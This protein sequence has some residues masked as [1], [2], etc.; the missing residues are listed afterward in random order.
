MNFFLP[1]L[2]AFLLSIFFTLLIRHVSLQKGIVDRPS[3]DL[4]RKVHERPIPLLGGFA[5]WAAFSITVLL[6]VIVAPSRFHESYLLFKHIFGIILGGALLMVG[7]YLDDRFGRSPRQQIIW[8]ILAALTVI[9]SGVGIA[10]ITNPF[11]GTIPL[12]QWIV[13]VVTIAGTPY[14]IVLFADVFA[15]L[16]LMVAM[17]ATKFLDG[18][19][20]LVSGVA[21]IGMLIIFA[22]SQT[23]EVGQPETALLALIAAASFAGFLIFNFHPAKIF[24]G[25]GGSLFA[26]FL[27][28]ALSIISGG[29][30]ATALL[31]LGV[32]LLD[33]VWV[34]FRRFIREHRSPFSSDRKH[35]HFR[36]LDLGLSHRSVVVFLYAITIL[37]G[38][39]TLIVESWQKAVI[40]GVLVISMILFAV[41]IG[42]KRKT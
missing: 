1:A 17:Y 15:F 29:K 24:L 22:L 8:P 20:G 3:A 19:D 26:G 33:V 37:L 36:L 38:T 16:W 41:W 5:I 27:L 34:V 13:N 42:A 35:F 30:I 28:A 21:V 10:Y 6:A 40:L 32:P 39:S 2:L 4:F 9:I 25:E 23:R 14:S 12:D 18:L 7:G 11:D 31:I